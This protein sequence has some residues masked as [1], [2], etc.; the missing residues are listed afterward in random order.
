[1]SNH[2]TERFNEQ[3]NEFKQEGKTMNTAKHTPTP[4]RYSFNPSGKFEIGTN[5]EYVALT[6]PYGMVNQP[7]EYYPREEANAEFIV[8]ACNAHEEL[9]KALYE[10]WNQ[11]GNVPR[12]IRTKQQQKALNLARLLMEK[13]GFIEALAKAEVKV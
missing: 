11:L 12:H 5:K 2:E 13:L 3:I 9:L 1:M 8:R 6:I 4:W 7:I 10:N